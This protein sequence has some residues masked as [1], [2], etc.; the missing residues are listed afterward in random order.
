MTPPRTQVA[1]LAFDKLDAEKGMEVKGPAGELRWLRNPWSVLAFQLAGA[2]GLRL[3]HAEGLGRRARER[4]R[5]EPAGG[6]AGD[7]R[8]ATAWRP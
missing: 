1:A 3:L 4:P 8:E 5:R 7:P 6:T 2:D